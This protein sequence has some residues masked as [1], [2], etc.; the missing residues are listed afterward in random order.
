[1][2]IAWDLVIRHVR[3]K[4]KSMR[5]G[6]PA[7]RRYNDNSNH[8]IIADLLGQPDFG[9]GS[10]LP[11][12]ILRFAVSH[13]STPELQ[14]SRGSFHVKALSSWLDVGRTAVSGPLLM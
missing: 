14:R 9:F 6:L 12:S 10:A 8:D 2:T 11:V 4:C 3:L 7:A 1:M 13:P 5:S